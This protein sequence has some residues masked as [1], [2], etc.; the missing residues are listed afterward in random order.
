MIYR[1]L[2][3]QGGL[4]SNPTVKQLESDIS[5]PTC[6]SLHTNWIVF[7]ASIHHDRREVIKFCSN[8]CIQ[9][10]TT[11]NTTTRMATI[12]NY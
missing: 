2:C 1:D 5:Y 3:Q 10:I 9:C 12:S 6:S 8:A 4:S 11:S 7:P